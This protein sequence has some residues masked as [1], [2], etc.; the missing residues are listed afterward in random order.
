MKKF[1]HHYLPLFLVMAAFLTA[2]TSC[3]NNYVMFDDDEWSLGEY[4]AENSQL[5]SELDLDDMDR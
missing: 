5:N 3:M 4:G 1:L 2:T